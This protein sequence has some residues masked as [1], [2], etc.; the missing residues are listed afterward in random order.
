MVI[1][2]HF[3]LF[4]I[5]ST[6]KANSQLGDFFAAGSLYTHIY[7]YLYINTYVNLAVC[8]CVFAASSC[9]LA[10]AYRRRIC[11]LVKINSRALSFINDSIVGV[12]SPKDITNF[13]FVYTRISNVCNIQIYTEIS[14]IVSND[15][16]LPFLCYKSNDSYFRLFFNRY[17]KHLKKLLRII[18]IFWKIWSIESKLIYRDDVG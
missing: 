13:I 8:M 1:R 10:G 18:G 7:I 9:P 16:L 17:L 5:K 2:H 6:P 11:L 15:F 4:P 14:I 12:W 3:R